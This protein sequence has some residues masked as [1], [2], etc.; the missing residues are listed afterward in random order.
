MKRAIK[1]LSVVIAFMLSLSV[2]SGCFLRPSSV[3]TITGPNGSKATVSFN[4]YLLSAYLFRLRVESYVQQNGST[5]KALLNEKT[6]DGTQTYNEYF[7][8]ELK[9]STLQN[10]VIGEK[11]KELNLS[12]TD[13]D[14]TANASSYEQF[15][16][17]YGAAAITKLR[18]E[19][20]LSESAFKTQFINF[21]N[22]QTKNTKVEDTVFGAGGSNEIKEADIKTAFQTDYVR[23]KHILLKTQKTDASGQAADMTADEIKVVETKAND[24]LKKAQAGQNFENLARYNSEDG[25]GPDKADDKTVKEDKIEASQDGSFL[26]ENYGYIFGKG[27]MAAE[28]ETASFE[29]KVGEI[30]MVKTTFGYHIIKKYDINEKADYY[31]KLKDKVLTGMKTTK[32]TTLIDEWSKNYTAKYDDKAFASY[33]LI[34]LKDILPV[35]ATSSAA[36]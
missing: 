20:R 23:V 21:L 31:D 4:N 16:S 7:T 34:N 35:A 3:A 29:L 12:L 6:Q 5:S 28:F 33:S 36:Q 2:L 25:A 18:G 1:L 15:V 8:A 24:L 10:Y 32:F 14:K 9:K 30:K 11:F 27:Q 26:I 19:L 13:A 22:E 17:Q